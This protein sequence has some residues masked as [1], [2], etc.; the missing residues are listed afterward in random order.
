M[1]KAI[2]FLLVFAAIIAV[3]AGYKIYTAPFKSQ[4]M[5]GPA[6]KYNSMVVKTETAQ[7][8][9]KPGSIPTSITGNLAGQLVQVNNVKFTGSGKYCEISQKGQNFGWINSNS[10]KT[11]KVYILPYT[12]TSQLYPTYAP[13]A[14]EAASLKMALSVKGIAMNT[15]FK[16]IVDRMPRNLNPNKGFNGNPYAGEPKGVIVTIYPKP[17]TAYAKKY[18]P[19][20]E[21]VTGISKSGLINEVKRGNSVV[22]SGA[23]RMLSNHGYHVLALVGYKPGYFLVAD[24]YMEPLWPHKVYWVS[25]AHFMNV[26]KIRG[27]RAVAIR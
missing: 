13:T 9:K 14:C 3:V 5:N 24:P 10:L 21:N 20:S 8:F 17:L 15:T 27:S 22:I 18:D 12:Y 23:W 2:K 25:T 16:D 26:F 11:T 6:N 7:L 1:R 4:A 19:N